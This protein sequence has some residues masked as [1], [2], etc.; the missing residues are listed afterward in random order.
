MAAEI[1]ILSVGFDD[2]QLLNFSAK[3]DGRFPENEISVDI[4]RF[5]TIQVFSY[6]RVDLAYN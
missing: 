4:C 3:K 2:L 5:A 1:A 6:K